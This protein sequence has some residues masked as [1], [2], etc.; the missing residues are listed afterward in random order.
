MKKMK[1]L[2]GVT[3]GIAAYKTCDLVRL[4]VKAGHEV[5]V[6]MTSSAAEFVTPMTF[7][8]L[9]HRPVPRGMF[10]RRSETCFEHLDLA[11]WGDIVVIAPATANIIGKI[12]AGIGDD[13]LTTMILAVPAKIPVLLAPAMNT[14]MWENPVV[15]RNLRRLLEETDG[16]YRTVGPVVKELAC[17]DLGMGGMASVETIFELVT[18][19]L[20]TS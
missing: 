4:L 8:A 6:I 7:E 9:S 18:K 20:H 17:G 15:Q 3:G 13:L 16:R 2:I 14:R 5:Q 19:Q 1:V 11:E 12:A 10:E